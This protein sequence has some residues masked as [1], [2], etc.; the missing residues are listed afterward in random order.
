MSG[1]GFPLISAEMLSKANNVLFMTHLALGDYIYQ[2]VYLEAL[3]QKHPNVTL[4][5][6]IDDCRTKKKSWHSGR[7]KTLSQWLE[8]EPHINHVYPIAKDLVHRQLI[9][10]EAHNQQ[11]DLIIFLATK[12]SEEYAKLARIISPDGYIAGTKSELFTKPFKKYWYFKQLSQSYTI[13]GSKKYSHITT[14]YNEQYTKLC[15]IHLPKNAFLRI[16][17]PAQY[18]LAAKNIIETSRTEN[19]LAAGPTI[20]INHLSTASKRDWQLTQLKTFLIK[21]YHNDNQ[22]LFILNSPPAQYQ[23]LLEWIKQDDKLNKLPIKVFSA[24]EHFYELP[25][26]MEQ[27]Q[28][29]ISVETAIMHIAAS[30]G[31]Q[32]IAL[33]RESA[34]QWQPLGPG[35]V[36]ITKGRVDN[37]TP[38]QVLLST[39]KLLNH[40]KKEIDA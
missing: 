32:Q 8:S 35:D 23:D 38:E 2:G 7:N 3:K 14:Y 1:I 15:G 19:A 34:Q 20:F 33:I 4:D 12:R 21:Q 24:K 25:A 37:I 31:I 11:Y 10:D 27:C 39:T 29:I 26:L 28:L 5:I 16:V 9:V 6:W 30:L 17:V 13:T 36:L 22:S 40:Q 18:Q